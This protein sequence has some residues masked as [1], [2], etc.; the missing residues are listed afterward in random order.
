MSSVKNSVKDSRNKKC[1]PL[2]PSECCHS[3]LPFTLNQNDLDELEKL[4]QA[5][6]R[7][8]KI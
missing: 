5:E 3:N 7:K 6:V 8:I 4:I 1:D 2:L